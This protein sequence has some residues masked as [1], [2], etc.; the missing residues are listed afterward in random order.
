MNQAITLELRELGVRFGALKA[1]ED[2]SLDL[3]GPERVGL[4]GPNGAGKTTLLNAISGFV[5]PSHGSVLLD[6]EDITE[7]TVQSRVHRGLV[8]SFQTARL[9]DDET[10]L[11]NTLLGCHPAPGPGS[12]RQ[13]MATRSAR[14][15][16]RRALETVR[17]IHAL[18]GLEQVAHQ[19]VSSLPSA[20]RRLVEVARVLASNPRIVLLDEPAAGLDVRER[21]HLSEVLTRIAD[22]HSL[23]MV[24]VEHDVAI[25]RRVCRHTVVLAEGRLLAEGRTEH[26]LARPDVRA[27]YFGENVN[28]GH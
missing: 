16:E 28:A 27:A 10:V 26:V 4:V 20:T 7:A 9:L 19:V 11:T 13:L 5:L 3:R 21:D 24:L 17:S 8:R 22:E 25:V 2:V 15:W 6:G 14:R 12:L 18:M 23:L 1:L